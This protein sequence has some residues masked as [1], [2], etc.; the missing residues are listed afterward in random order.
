VAYFGYY[1]SIA[2]EFEAK[3]A[4]F[5]QHILIVQR[6]ERG[7]TCLLTLKRQTFHV[8]LGDGGGAVPHASQCC[9]QTQPENK[10]L[11][12]KLYTKLAYKN[13][14]FVLNIK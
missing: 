13:L 2:R 14:H 12:E 9:Q 8:E 6:S 1:P 4:T 5:S 7:L 10:T 3:Y 11:Y